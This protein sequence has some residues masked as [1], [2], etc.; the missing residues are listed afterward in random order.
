MTTFSKDFN[1]DFLIGIMDYAEMRKYI[2]QQIFKQGSASA[3]VLAPLFNAII[4]KL[5]TSESPTSKSV[6]MK[7][8]TIGEPAKTGDN[9]SSNSYR[10]TN[11]QDDIDAIIDA[12]NENHDLTHVA[13]LDNNLA[14]IFNFLEY[15]DQEL[16]AVATTHD[17]T[18][19]LHLSKD[20]DG[21]YM[22][23]TRQSEMV[24]PVTKAEIEVYKKLFDADY[25][26]EANLFKVQIG[27]SIVNLTPADML[28]A[29]QEY[30]K[31]ANT[32]NY[33]AMWANSKAKYIKCHDWFEGFQSDID[34][35]SAFYGADAEII[36]LN[37]NSVD[38][39]ML[40]SNCTNMFAG[41]INLQQV[42]GIIS[43]PDTGYSVQN[44][45]A[46]CDKLI[47][48]K[49]KNLSQDLDLSDC[50]QASPE[51]VLYAVQ[52][53]KATSGII[54]TLEK[55][56]L[57]KYSQSSDWTEVRSAVENNQFITIA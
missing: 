24:A 47:S 49:L 8:I 42:V 36:D 55:S 5:S 46:S 37:A 33:T 30:D 1:L 52:N 38:G 31:V 41:C 19:Y 11:L 40:V 26:Y 34:M 10:V 12:A 7:A 51:S 28:L 14:I 50:K 57:E 20:V 9:L 53:A 48:F 25:D 27:T 39:E 13:V 15:S 29:D 16:T 21:S 18:Y 22:N 3:K 4:D 43:L 2:E 6:V 54:I 35:H 56:V 32:V 44:I 45:F 17:G 23:W